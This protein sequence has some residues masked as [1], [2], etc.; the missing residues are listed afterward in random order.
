MFLTRWR[1]KT[2]DKVKAQYLGGWEGWTAFVKSE[3]RAEALQRS[4][5]LKLAA[6]TALTKDPAY[7]SSRDVAT[8]VAWIK[9]VGGALRS[10]RRAAG[11]RVSLGRP[12]FVVAPLSSQSPSLLPPFLL[13][14]PVLGQTAR[15]QRGPQSGGR[16]GQVSQD[17]LPAQELPLGE[18]TS[19]TK[20]AVGSLLGQGGQANARL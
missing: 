1:N 8:A 18:S 14:P 13:C 6:L 20:T 2:L 9:Q 4:A 17:L 15:P 10:G 16:G 19:Y 12:D 3:R 5:N 11:V 7:R